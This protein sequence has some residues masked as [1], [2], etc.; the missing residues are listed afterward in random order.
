MNL[1]LAIS[2]CSFFFVVVESAQVF[3]NSDDRGLRHGI[4]QI[5]RK[6]EGNFLS[7]VINE[8]GN[9]MRELSLPEVA[10]FDSDLS[11][12][13]FR[14]GNSVQDAEGPKVVAIIWN[15]KYEVL[16]AKRTCG[17]QEK[18]FEFPRGKPKLIDAG[19]T[20]KS[21][22]PK[23][24]HKNVPDADS[25]IGGT[26]SFPPVCRVSQFPFGRAHLKKNSGSQGSHMQEKTWTNWT[27]WVNWV[28]WVNW[29][30]WANWS[31]WVKWARGFSPT[32]VSKQVPKRVETSEETVR[33]EVKEESKGFD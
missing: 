6:S 2:L 17:K 4:D 15:D 18:G 14:K 9:E 11:L 7:A 5:S 33:R 30:N 13:E 20:P 23:E 8:G 26:Q 10:P 27:N 19:Q 28:N 25:D 31:K 12:E 16:L 22:N 29:S 3:R 1:H 24:D 32:T 21:T